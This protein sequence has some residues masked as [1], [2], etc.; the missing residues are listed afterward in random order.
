M[1]KAYYIGQRIRKAKKGSFI[2]TISRLTVFTVAV[3]IAVMI[4]TYSILGGFKQTIKDKLFSFDSHIQLKKFELTDAFITSPML[5]DSVYY[6]ELQ[7]NPSIKSANTYGLS[8]GILQKDQEVG[9]IVF[10]GVNK[11]FNF[12]VFGQNIISGTALDFTDKNQVLLS[13]RI[14]RKFDLKVG[15]KFKVH[16][17]NGNRPKPRNFIIQG[18]FET[19]LEEIDDHFLL[20]DMA[21]LRNVSNWSAKEIG[22][23][24][25]FLHNPFDAKEVVEEIQF[26]SSNFYDTEAVLIT[27]K[28][29]YLFQWLE[30]IDQNAIVMVVII[31]IIVFFN[32][33]STMYI[34]ITDRTSTIGLL[35]SMGGTTA[36]LVK[37]FWY[38]SIQLVIKGV[39]W[40]NFI[41]IG[42]CLLQL[43]FKILPLDPENYYMD[44]VP[45]L[46]QW[47][48]WAIINICTV[49]F[50]GIIIII[51]IATTLKMKPVEA[52]R[53]S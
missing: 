25:I 45:I 32:L 53:F 24:E 38:S 11:D 46:W 27:E 13:S 42:F 48:T 2:Q 8:A 43:Y 35:K 37:I 3:G 47:T 30:M 10:K 7:K 34:L 31:F 15:D 36:F 26:S 33:L 18:I 12:D 49:V 52:I 28:Y 23:Y 50:V 5:K 14:A 4:I 22:G 39:L 51:P 40:G 29:Q 9:G 17:F 19:G 16:F 44:A 20:G 41:A 6:E 21:M 1:N